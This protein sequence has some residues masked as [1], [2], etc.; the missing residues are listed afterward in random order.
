MLWNPGLWDT[1]EY[2]FHWSIVTRQAQA[3]A[4]RRRQA[5]AGA[6]RPGRPGRPGI[7]ILYTCYLHLI[8]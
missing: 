2:A 5:Q 4:G 8:L 1:L 7:Y 6:G 3:G